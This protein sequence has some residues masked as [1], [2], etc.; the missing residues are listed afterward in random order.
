MSPADHFPQELLQQS[1]AARVTYFKN[2]TVAHPLLKEVDT[3]LWQVVQAPADAELVCLFGPTGVGKTTLIQRLTKRLLE[4]GRAEM[5]R[6]LNYLPVAW[7]DAIAPDNRNFSWMDYYKRALEVLDD[8]FY[9]R[10]EFRLGPGWRWS[11]RVMRQALERGLKQRR[12]IA[13]II[14]EAQHLTKMSSGRKLQD[15]MDCIKSLASTSGT[16]HILCGTYELL[17]FRNLS[18]QLVRRSIDLHFRR[19][20]I[21]QE[22]ELKAWRSVLWAFQR[23]LPLDEEPD[24]VSQWEF[25]FER[26]LGCVGILKQW[27]LRVLQTA[28]D[29]DRRTIG[30]REVEEQSLP[31]SQCEKM[32]TEM[33]EG[34]MQLTEKQESRARL[35]VLLGL[36]HDSAPETGAA[37][38]KKSSGRVGQRNPKRDPVRGRRRA[39]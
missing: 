5:K 22:E 38:R 10:D 13:F 15:Q 8:P 18:A 3:K 35:R 11:A 37:K 12:L 25:C 31:A 24:L 20:R 26:S 28:L 21:E 16:L 19:Y 9:G 4:Q 39:G 1:K 7:V 14:D 17:A 27:L 23:H 34:E 36:H 32:A 6:D 30:R 29:K 33:L 2:Y